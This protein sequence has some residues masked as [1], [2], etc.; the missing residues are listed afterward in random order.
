[1]NGE[2]GAGVSF[3]S[4]NELSTAFTVIG[5]SYDIAE[6]TGKVTADFSWKAW[7]PLIDLNTSYGARASYTSGDS[8]V[9]FTFNEAIVSAGLSLPLL[10]TG[11]KY[12]KGLR[13]QLH[14]SL[15]NITNN[16]SI[17]EN[18]L[19]GTINSLDYSV[20]A[21]RYIKQ[22][23][24]DIYPRWGQMLSATFRHSPFG[25]NNLGSI[26]SISTRFYFPGFVQ[27][28][29]FRFDL[30]LQQ[31]DE[32]DYAY[33]NQIYFPRGYLSINAANIKCFAVN[34]KFPFAYPD[35]SL[36][37]VVYFKRLK[38]NL[39]YDGGMAADKGESSRLQSTGV[40]LTAD[41]HLLRFIFPF[42]IGYRLGY[43]PIEKQYF[44]DLL[45]SVNLSN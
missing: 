41:L 23:Y 14:S 9:R 10:F 37:P 44:G 19:T 1:M 5:Y 3:M 11:G 17:E 45:F 21:Y 24:K 8:S 12:Y 26:F 29:G 31:K 36:G 35:F 18:K 32:G 15:H 2:N 6:N 27:H 20:S 4:Q 43:R 33:N 13:F 38:V 42:D 16:S 25:D 28:H 7:Y 40:E 30:S 22:S 39:F 34:Y